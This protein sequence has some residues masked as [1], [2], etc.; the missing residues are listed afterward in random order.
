MEVNV[1]GNPN[2]ESLLIQLHEAWAPTDKKIVL[3]IIKWGLTHP[4]PQIRIVAQESLYQA[5]KQSGDPRAAVSSVVPI[6]ALGLMDNDIEIQT[7]SVIC[8]QIVAKDDGDLTPALSVLGERLVDEGEIAEG[9]ARA[10]WLGGLGSTAVGK[11]K[12][13]LEQALSSERT[14][15][16]AYSS[17]ALSRYFRQTGTETKLNADYSGA[18]VVDGGWSYMDGPVAVEVSHRRT[19][20]ASDEEISDAALYHLC[21]VCGSR[22]TLCI[23]YEIDAGTSWKN[24]KYEILCRKCGKYTVYE[25]DW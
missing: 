8:L 23:Y 10:I 18:W 3:G 20:A 17:M 15:V 9:A 7:Q 21:G 2:F 5:E 13:R 14:S 25:Y 19:Y 22:E 1:E 24:E 6:L 11:I 12:E 16:R 4:D